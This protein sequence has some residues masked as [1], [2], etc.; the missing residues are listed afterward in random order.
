MP[1]KLAGNQY[2]KSISIDKPP[3]WELVR[4]LVLDKVG[5]RSNNLLFRSTFASCEADQHATN[6]I[7]GDTL[8][9]T[10]TAGWL[11]FIPSESQPWVLQYYIRR[12]VRWGLSRRG[13]SSGSSSLFIRMMWLGTSGGLQI[14]GAP[15]CAGWWQHPGDPQS[16]AESLNHPG[17]CRASL[18]LWVLFYG[19][20]TWVLLKT[21]LASL[22]GFHI[23][24]SGG[25]SP[26][27]FFILAGTSKF[28]DF[29]RVKKWEESKKREEKQADHGDGGERFRPWPFSSSPPSPPWSNNIIPFTRESVF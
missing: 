12:S 8:L 5:H 14:L 9:W 3:T 25:S 1:N 24:E 21:A 17:S 26:P 19:C 27:L 6:L 20:E 13:L 23:R 7:I 22:E 15:A 16:V 4:E 10:P 2:L 11:L 28:E 29:R 18:A